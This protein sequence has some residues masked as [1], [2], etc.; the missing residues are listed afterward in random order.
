M[1]LWTFL[2][3]ISSRFWVDIRSCASGLELVPPPEFKERPLASVRLGDE[4]RLP[5]LLG[6]EDE[7]A[8]VGLR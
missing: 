8:L 4:W 5:G 6:A 3:V 7:V 1:L 2:A